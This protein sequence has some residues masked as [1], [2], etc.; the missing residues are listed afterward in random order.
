M[1]KVTPALFLKRALVY[2][3]G[4]LVL[5]FGV[6]ISVNSNLGVSPVSSLP[7]V[8]SRILNAPLGTCVTVTYCFFILLQVLIQRRDFKPVNLL[9]ILFST[10]F[11]YFVDFAEMVMQGWAFDSYVG[12]LGMLAAS[13]VMIAVGLLIYMDAQLVPMP[14]EGLVACIAGKTGKTFGNVKT[15]IDCLVVVIGIVL[16]FI[17]LGEIQ[18]IREGT[19]ITAIVTGKLMGV[20]RKWITPKVRQICAAE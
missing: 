3:M 7:Y 16:C 14:M 12:R 10:I 18:G 2:C 5:A 6:V 1:K 11:G 19:I 9:E 17:F 8:I 20:L 13:I 15:V 4:L